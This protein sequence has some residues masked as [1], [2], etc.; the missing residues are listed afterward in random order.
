M[1]EGSKEGSKEIRNEGRMEDACVPM[2]RV[3]SARK[4][5]PERLSCIAG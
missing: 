3:L 1:K 2:R 5:V 4:L